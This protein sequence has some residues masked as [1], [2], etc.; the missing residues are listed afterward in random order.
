M[1]YVINAFPIPKC[2]IHKVYFFTYWNGWSEV[3]KECGSDYNNNDLFCIH[4]TFILNI[5]LCVSMYDKKKLLPIYCLL[6]K[7]IIIYE[8]K[9]VYRN[10]NCFIIVLYS[11][12]VRYRYTRTTYLQKCWNIDIY[13]EMF[14]ILISKI[15][16]L[17][18]NEFKKK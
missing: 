8:L 1:M 7:I 3:H 6:H 11:F 12:I 15:K 4:T 13:C 5:K 9:R 18:H 17:I 16:R 10:M 2:T 14:C